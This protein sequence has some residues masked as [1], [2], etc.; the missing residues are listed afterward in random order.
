MS[1][2]GGFRG[3]GESGGGVNKVVEEGGDVGIKGF[4]DKKC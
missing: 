2:R 3:E 1:F 4:G